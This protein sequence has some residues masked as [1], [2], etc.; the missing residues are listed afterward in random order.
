LVVFDTSLINIKVQKNRGFKI[1]KKVS[2]V[3]GEF[4]FVASNEARM[5]LIHFTFLKKC[6]KK[7]NLKKKKEKKNSFKNFK[8]WVGLLPNSVMS[9]KSKNARMGKGKG[10]FDR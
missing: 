3:F 6:L 2:L 7:L 9:K 10:M 5:E 8:I 4:G 1:S